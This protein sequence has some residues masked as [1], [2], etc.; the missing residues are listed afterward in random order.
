MKHLFWAMALLLCVGYSG[1]NSSEKEQLAEAEAEAARI[2]KER[3]AEA[4][5]ARIEKSIEDG[6]GRDG[7]YQIGD[8]YNR[9]GNKGVVIEISNGGRNGKILSLDETECSWSKAKQ[10][11]RNHGDGWRLPTKDELLVIYTNKLDVNY[12]LKRCNSGILKDSWYWT[13]TEYNSDYAWLVG[14]NDGDT[15]Y[16]AKSYHYY[17]RA[18]YEF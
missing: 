16:Y 12:W 18:V 11:C 4:E 2:E 10:W 7:I 17:V 3:L 6:L 1:S 9:N 5:A 8:Y 13:S 14:M 15:S